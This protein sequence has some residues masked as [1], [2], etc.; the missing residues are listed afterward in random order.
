M[1]PLQ[2]SRY[3]LHPSYPV[4]RLTFRPS[5]VPLNSSLD[6]S[7]S[8]LSPLPPF[9]WSV[10]FYSSSYYYCYFAP[11]SPHFYI[12]LG[13]TPAVPT[14][15]ARRCLL[16]VASSSCH[17]TM[18]CSAASRTPPYNSFLFFLLLAVGHSAVSTPSTKQR[19]GVFR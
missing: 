7:H 19:R 13:T 11:T 18:N 14:T 8:M 17:S 1:L 10:S 15:G 6:F 4:C 9:P 16:S 2:L 5:Q 3:H 12:P